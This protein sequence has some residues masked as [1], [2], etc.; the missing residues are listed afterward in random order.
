MKKAVSIAIL[1]ATLLALLGC[2]AKFYK[3]RADKE[4][5]SSGNTGVCYSY[6]LR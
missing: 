4:V 6:M 2:Y 1:M 5:A 3:K